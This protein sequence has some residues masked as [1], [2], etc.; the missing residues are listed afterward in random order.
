MLPADSV[1]ENIK[2][3]QNLPVTITALTTLLA[4][5]HL[6]CT[7]LLIKKKRGNAVT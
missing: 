1:Q 5:F 2:I 4:R 6:K 7:R 3:K